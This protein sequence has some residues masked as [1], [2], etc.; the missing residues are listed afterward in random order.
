[1]RALVNSTLLLFLI[2]CVNSFVK[3]TLQVLCPGGV[4]IFHSHQDIGC[5][6]FSQEGVIYC[7]LCLKISNECKCLH[8]FIKFVKLATA[9]F[10][11][12]LVCLVL[13]LSYNVTLENELSAFLTQRQREG[14]AFSEQ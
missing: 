10:C 2:V 7:K 9:L 12:V 1:M 5:F 3:I 8:A 11:L 4:L 13:S 6:S 14:D